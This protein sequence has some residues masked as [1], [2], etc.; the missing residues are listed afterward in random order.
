MKVRILD[1]SA[2]NV[3]TP[4]ALAAYSGSVGWAKVEPYGDV[5]D[6]WSGKGLPEI[7]LPRTNRLGDYAS[8]VSRLIEI[9]SEERGQGELAVLK[10]LL[11]ADHDVIRVR[12]I[13]GAT[14]GSIALDTGVEMVSQAREMVLAAARATVG[15]PQRVYRGRANKKAT[16]FMERVRLGQTEHGSFVVSLMAP[17]APTTATL[18]DDSR[19]WLTDEPLSRRVVLRLIE[20][21]QASRQA[22]ERWSSGSF[23]QEFD[24]AI[25]A[26]VSA[27]LCDAVVNL[28]EST[29]RFD[30]SVAWATSRAARLPPARIEF[31][32]AHRL[33][34]KAFAQALRIDGPR[35]EIPLLATVHRLTRD[36]GE[37]EG[38]VVLKTEIDGRIYSVNA[39]LDEKNYGVAIRAHETGR[40]II[41]NG[42][43]ERIGQRW[44]ITNAS[45]R[46]LPV[47][48]D[49]QPHSAEG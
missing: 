41:V 43:L 47:G 23:R 11:E 7:V 21:L 39:V 17:V 15:P 46:E 33:A 34:L 42:D 25:S 40:R 4:R 19:P 38:V 9:F 32:E 49:D 30:V 29:D 18:W 20:A 44:R 12:V 45:V 37:L 2:L 14:N 26:G 28:I 13:E 8:V 36:K 3:V 24:A 1:A 22:A 10:D 16:A 6:V 35:P 31:S 5:A 27:N 48:P